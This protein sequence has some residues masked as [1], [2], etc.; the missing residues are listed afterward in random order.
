MDDRAHGL[1]VPSSHKGVSVVY[2][3]IGLCVTC[4]GC[5]GMQSLQGL[6]LAAEVMLAKIFLGK[7]IPLYPNARHFISGCEFK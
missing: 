4:F 7:E 1:W 2:R 5:G 6:P 3:S